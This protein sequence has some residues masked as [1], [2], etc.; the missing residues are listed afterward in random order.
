MGKPNDNSYETSK[1]NQHMFIIK[2]LK[3]FIDK[4]LLRIVYKFA[5]IRLDQIYDVEKLIT[6]L[7]LKGDDAKKFRELTKLT[8]IKIS[9]DDE[10]RKIVKRISS[11]SSKGVK[12]SNVDNV[13]QAEKQVENC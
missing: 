11:V 7:Q 12:V 8:A 4:F 1:K 9:V 5:G 3:G 10:T 13:N 6:C 2:K